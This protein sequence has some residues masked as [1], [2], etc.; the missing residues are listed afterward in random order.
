M[1]PQRKADPTT[2]VYIPSSRRIPSPTCAKPE[3][4]P[5]A[6]T[7]R[8]YVL[9]VSPSGTSPTSTIVPAKLDRRSKSSKQGELLDTVTIHTES[10]VSGG[11]I[12]VD[13]Y[14]NRDLLR[15]PVKREKQQGEHMR[16]IGRCSGL[17]SD[18]SDCL[19]TK[20]GDYQANKGSK[21]QTNL[22]CKGDLSFSPPLSS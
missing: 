16:E 3:S 17:E 8:I 13:K 4:P 5:P 15:S 14:P 22:H 11:L 19:E 21:N 7:P 9:P 20:S 6:A 2:D 1:S 10:P 12:K 18:E